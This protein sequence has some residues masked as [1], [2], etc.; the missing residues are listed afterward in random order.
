MT[1]MDKEINLENSKLVIDEQDKA[2]IEKWAVLVEDRAEVLREDQNERKRVYRMRYD[3]Y[4]GNHSSY[5]TIVGI[6]EKE[7]KGHANAVINY[8]GKTA[9]K[10]GY[11]LANNPPKC[12]V[13]ARRVPEESLDVERTRSQAVEDFQDEVFSR[14]RFW[15]GGYRRAC[16]N[17]IISADAAIKSYVC[18]VGTKEEPVWEIKVINHEKMQNVLVGWRSDDPTKY[19]YVIVED[20]RSIQSIFDEYGIEIPEELSTAANKEDAKSSGSSG[21]FNDNQWGSKSVKGAT[22]SLPTGKNAV[23]KVKILE[24]DDENV[25][26]IKIAGQV[27][28]LVYKDG[29]TAPKVAYWTI[30]HN[31]FNPESPWSISDI[32]YLMDPQTELNEASNEE[33]DY[34]RVGANQKYVA[35]NM[36]EFDPESIKPGSGGVIFVESTN[37]ESRFEPLNTNIN[38]FPVD[39]F[40]TR[41]QNHL[42]DLGL[43][44][45]SYGSTGGDS[46]RAKAIDYQTMVDLVVFK[47]DAWELAMD[48]ICEKIQKF[49]DFYFGNE[50]DIF[51]DPATS[52]FVT[53]RIEFD[54]SDILPITQ[55]D[56]IVNIVN[57]VQMGLPYSIA[58]KELGYRDVESVIDEMEREASNENL[59]VF[60]SKMWQVTPG[61]IQ[62]QTEA[63]MAMQQNMAGMDPAAGGGANEAGPTL[64][65][66][67]NAGRESSLP[68]SQTRGTS[69]YS[70]AGGQ[71]DKAKQN[72]AA[73]GL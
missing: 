57:K 37:G 62:A 60:R 5:S 52:R 16:F 68:M 24:Y 20:E 3:F 8:A 22:A 72:L 61:L 6:R 56:K 35:Y 31:I 38:S 28:Q 17:Q 7:K 49:G 59:M 40:L 15:K 41:Q 51:K 11:S 39:S 18:N 42:Y 44:K 25:Y 71:I 4:R 32:D 64:T 1:Q 69:Y 10:I 66:S 53:R 30:V 9:V 43:P 63:Q 34:I 55:G 48:E 73:R 54:W 36:A 70:T 67:Q 33:R 27:V 2:K 65:N 58:W 50:I 23:P 45:V 12:S 26:I 47:R 21:H 13:L 46:G 29:V 14:N 19:D